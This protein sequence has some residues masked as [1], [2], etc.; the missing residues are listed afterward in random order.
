[1]AESRLKI[2]TAFAD[3]ATRDHEFGPFATNSSAIANIKTNIAAFNSNIADFGAN[4]LSDGG[5]TCTGIVKAQ[6]ITTD[7][8]EIN[9]N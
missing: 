9:L 4:Y 7:E 2:R 5:A 6:I 8:T 3:E 1:M